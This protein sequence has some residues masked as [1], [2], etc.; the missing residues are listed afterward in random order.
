MLGQAMTNLPEEEQRDHL[1]VLNLSD[2]TQ[3]ELA[4]DFLRSA[5]L[6][7]PLLYHKDKL[8]MTGS[9]EQ[10]WNAPLDESKLI[11]LDVAT[12]EL[13]TPLDGYMTGLYITDSVWYYYQPDANVLDPTSEHTNPGFRE[14][15]VEHG[16]V[17]ECGLPADD[18]LW[19]RYDA[20]F[21]YA[22]S[23]YRNGFDSRTLY[24]LSR[25]YQIL[26]QIEL[27]GMQ[28]IAAVTN[29]RIYFSN[30]YWAPINCYLE[31]SEVRNHALELK[32]IAHFGAQ[33]E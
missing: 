4:E 7:F 1:L 12:G 9:V 31:K 10:R 21:I 20:D 33:D 16:T 15:D 13:R 28:T 18:I 26:G 19:A 14:Y 17:R 3:T 27:K 25:E 6:S 30:D 24:I 29:D 5:S 23:N 2:N 11:E 22:G 32:P 8:Y